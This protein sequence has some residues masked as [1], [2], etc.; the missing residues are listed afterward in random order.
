MM[1]SCTADPGELRHKFLA[2]NNPNRRKFLRIHIQVKRIINQL[3]FISPDFFLRG[4]CLHFAGPNINRDPCHGHCTVPHIIIP[5]ASDA[6]LV[7]AQIVNGYKRFLCSRH[8]NPL[9]IEVNELH[10]VT[11]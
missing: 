8:H 6:S 7:R 11:S 5:P 1:Q 9:A 10:L 3:D 2:V 4:T